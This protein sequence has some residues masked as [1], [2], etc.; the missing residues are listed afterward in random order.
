MGRVV[1]KSKNQG[2]FAFGT[3]NSI[4]DYVPADAKFANLRVRGAFVFSDEYDGAVQEVKNA[5]MISGKY[6]TMT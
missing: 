2:R 3:W 5:V 6:G 1:A 4:P